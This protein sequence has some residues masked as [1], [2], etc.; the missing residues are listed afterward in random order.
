MQKTL[1]NKNIMVSRSLV[2][3]YCTS[4]EMQGASITLTKLDKELKKHWDSSCTYSCYEM[5]FIKIK[6]ELLFDNNY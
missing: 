1:N 5:G 2:G 6:S 4:L 3:N